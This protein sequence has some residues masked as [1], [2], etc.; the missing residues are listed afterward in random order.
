MRHFSF[1]LVLHDASENFFFQ[2]RVSRE[3]REK[4]NHFS[5]PSEKSQT[6]SHKNS[7]DRLF[8]LNSLLKHDLT[9]SPYYITCKCFIS[10][11]SLSFWRNSRKKAHFLNFREDYNSIILDQSS[12][13][14]EFNTFL[15]Y[16]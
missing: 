4:E 12:R 6:D 8:S 14:Y 5:W 10:Y 13:V 7:Q 9:I 16:N 1:N 3:E 15:N 2:Y 11:I